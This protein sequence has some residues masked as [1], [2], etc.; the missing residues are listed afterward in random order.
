MTVPIH[1]YC[2]RF[3]SLILLSLRLLSL[4]LLSLLSCRLWAAES[5]VITSGEWAPYISQK[6]PHYGITSRIVTEAFKQQNIETQYQF[7]PWNRSLNSARGGEVNATL[8]WAKTEERE[9][10][11]WFSSEPIS[12]EQTVFFYRADR[13]L[14]WQQIWSDNSR[15][16]KVGATLGYEYGSEFD[17]AERRGHFQVIRY[18]DDKDGF[19]LLKRKKIDFFAMDLIVAEHT[20]KRFYPTVRDTFQYVSQPLYVVE[21]YLL[22]SKKDKRNL[23]L[24]RAFDRG[25]KALKTSG[26]LKALTIEC[27]KRNV[28]AARLA[29][30][31]M[32]SAN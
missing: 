19:R 29:C 2:L 31:P 4:L 10:D 30:P 27:S 3:L 32:P 20:L 8:G 21:L 7:Y 28:P 16:F 11:F 6:L 24:K 25:Y 26:R 18:P 1:S 5:I 22:F 14:D 13:P 23:Q 12:I 9:Q 17:L 15:G